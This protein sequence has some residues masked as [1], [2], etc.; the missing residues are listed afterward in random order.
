MSIDL[1]RRTAYEQ[2]QRAPQRPYMQQRDPYG[3][4][5]PSTPSRGSYYGQGPP[6]G[7][8]TVE[9]P[10][11]HGRTNSSSNSSPFL[12]PR[13]EYPAY[14][15]PASNSMYQPHSRESP[16]Q[17]QQ[18]QYAP[19]Q[20]RPIPQL[21]QPMPPY[22]PLP[23]SLPS[24]PE[25]PRAHS[26]AFETD[27]PSTTSRGYEQ[28]YNNS[29][30]PPINYDRQI[31]PLAR[32]LPAPS[33]NVTSLLPPLQSFDSAQPRRDT[34]QSYSSSGMSNVEANTQLPSSFPSSSE[35]PNYLPQPYRGRE[36]G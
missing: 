8:A 23:S 14:Q 7:P 33:Q 10:F 16:H 19:S 18:S 13:T 29:Q 21:A 17:Y 20:P 12:S 15:F 2:D 24:Q 6:T 35:A 22:R 3:Q 11:S 5:A 9:Y 25:Q 32:T 36:N 31:Q 26:R 34:L 30:Y 4:Y 28:S 1:A 27:D